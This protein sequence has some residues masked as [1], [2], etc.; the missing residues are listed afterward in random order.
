[1]KV[2]PETRRAHTI[3]YLLFY[4]YTKIQ[5]T[6]LKRYDGTEE[7]EAQFASEEM[8]IFILIRTI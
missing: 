1:M 4:I 6:P 5:N 8:I 3:R 2:I 7:P